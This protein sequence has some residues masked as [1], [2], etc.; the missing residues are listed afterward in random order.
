[1][2]G[3]YGRQDRTHCT[4]NLIQF[5]LNDTMTSPD[6]NDI[7]IAAVLSWVVKEIAAIQQTMLRA[8]DHRAV[9]V[10]LKRRKRPLKCLE[11]PISIITPLRQCPS[12]L[13]SRSALQGAFLSGE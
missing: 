5:L 3:W 1:M 12:F 9:H 6:S 8:S 13:L 10:D 4:W 2:G 7:Q 11:S